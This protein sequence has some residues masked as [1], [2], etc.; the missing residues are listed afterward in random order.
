VGFRRVVLGV[1]ASA[2]LVAALFSGAAAAWASSSPAGQIAFVRGGDVWTMDASG[3]DARRLTTASASEHDPA[4]SPDGGTIACIRDGG[5]GEVWL[6]NA[7]GTDQRRL[8]FT[9]NAQTMPG[10]DDPGTVR[11]IDE[12]AWAPGGADITVCASAFTFDVPG[13]IFNNQL[14]LVHPDGTSQRRI[15]PLIGGAYAGIDGLSW[16]PDGSQVLLSQ[17]F[18]QGGGRAVAYD[19]SSD[20]VTVPFP[21]D[22]GGRPMWCAVWSPGGDYVAASVTD[23]ESGS[24]MGLKHVAV[25][26]MATRSER[27]LAP[28]AQAD[29]RAQ[30]SSTWSP[31]GQW[32]ACSYY[33]GDEGSRTY[34]QSTDGA[35]SRLLAENAS[36]PAWSP[37]ASSQPPVPAVA[38]T[39]KLTGLKRGTLKHGKSVAAKGS[40]TPISLA[41]SKVTL[42][43]Q[44]KRGSTWVKAAAAST[45]INAAGAYS[46]TYRPTKKGSC[47]IRTTIAG[48]TAHGAAAS[49]WVAFKVN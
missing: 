7:D 20:Q 12:V 32:L 46:W 42:T 44:F 38:V 34:L 1:V 35:E 49:R 4:W 9:L 16:R 6:M 11:S 41:G 18:R 14:Y 19:L 13:G 27:R 40:V 31:D 39:L 8:P 37:T 2:L 43:V 3:A 24:S 23:D 28:P 21:G 48:T 15:G 22:Y 30:A 36:E 25:I 45:A 33:W 17:I 29:A 26:N 10:T 47:R 5:Q